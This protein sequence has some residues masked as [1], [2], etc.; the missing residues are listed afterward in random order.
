[1][2]GIVAD[3]VLLGRH[4]ACLAQGSMLWGAELLSLTELPV[5][6]LRQAA[7]RCMFWR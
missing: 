4:I 1:M 2:T 5:Q 7:S 6:A 3:Q